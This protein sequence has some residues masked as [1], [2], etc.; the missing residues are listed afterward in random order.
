M[1]SGIYKIQNKINNKGYYGSTNDFD[2]RKRNHFSSLRHNKHHNIHL[3]RAFNKYGEIN[4]EFVIIE[5]VAEDQLLD[6]EQKYLDGNCGG[7]NVAKIADKPPS[8]KG[9]P[10]REE[11]KEKM[12]CAKLG[13]KCSDEHKRNVGLA[14][15]G[16]T[17]SAESK[18][19]VSNSLLGNKN[20]LGNIVSDE[21]RR[22]MSL[23]AKIRQQL[24]REAKN[25]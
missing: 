12:R 11:T 16:R 14:S 6:V 18:A 7:Y 17:K 5:L 3:Q 15:R 21:T 1:N 19:K 20:S 23:A 10:K 2:V 25:D 8:Q 22:K 9:I 24:L 4:F 13:Y